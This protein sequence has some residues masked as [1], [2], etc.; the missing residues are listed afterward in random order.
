MFDYVISRKE[1]TESMER[2]L[3]TDENYKNQPQNNK[4]NGRII[5]VEKEHYYVKED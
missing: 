5:S 1:R 3:L 4:W 2:T